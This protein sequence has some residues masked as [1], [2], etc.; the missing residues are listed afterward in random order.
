V[1][2][3]PI[4]TSCGGTAWETWVCPRVAEVS[5]A[6][7]QVSVHSGCI[8]SIY[9]PLC[10]GPFPFDDEEIIMRIVTQL[11]TPL[12]LLPAMF[13]PIGAATAAPAES[14]R[15]EGPLFAINGCNGEEVPMEGTI[16]IVRKKHKGVLVE[17]VTIHGQGVGDQGNEYVLNHTSTYEATSAVFSFDERIL[18]ISKGSA[19]NHVLIGHFGSDTEP[20]FETVC[21]G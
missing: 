16:H 7:R 18:A 5:L 15:V 12:V 21:R 6:E 10:P 8:F 1:H 17:H 11:L 4:V 2:C 9:G 3:N 19:P 14:I 13:L 20:T